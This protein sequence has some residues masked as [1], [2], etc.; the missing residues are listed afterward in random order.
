MAF[1]NLMTFPLT[2]MPPAMMIGNFVLLH[3]GG[4]ADVGLSGLTSSLAKQEDYTGPRDKF[5]SRMRV[6]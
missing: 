2:F 3:E 4:Y 1:V 5:F 6:E